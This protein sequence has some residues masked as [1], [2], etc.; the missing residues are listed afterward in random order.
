MT[1]KGSMQSMIYI[2]VKLI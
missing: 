1:K 2:A